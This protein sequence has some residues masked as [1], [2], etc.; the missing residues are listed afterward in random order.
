METKTETRL[1]TLPLQDIN[2]GRTN[3]RKVFGRDSLKELTKSILEKGILQP[4][5]VRPVND[6]FELVCGERRLRAATMAKLMEVPVQIRELTDEEVVEVQ[7]IENLEREDVHPLQEAEVLQKMLDSEKYTLSDLAA[8]LAKSETFI[9][10]RLSLNLLIKPWKDAFAAD[11]LSLGKAL[12]VARLTKNGQK[13]LAENAMDYVG[14]IKS[15]AAL[16]RYIDQNISRKL[17]RATFDPQDG[18]LVKKAG[19]CT[20]CQKRS[21]ANERLFPDIEAD[22][23]CFDRKCYELKVQAHLMV[24]IRNI[25]EAGEPV[26]FLYRSH[27]EETPSGFVKLFEKHDIRPLQEYDD[28]EVHNNGRSKE[29]DGLWLNGSSKG[30]RIRIFLPQRSKGKMNELSPEEQI[31]RIEQ[32]ASRALEL[33]AEKIHKRIIASLEGTEG[34]N[35]IGKIS[36]QP[37]DQLLMRLSLWNMANWDTREQLSKI[38]KWKSSRSQKVMVQR[39]EKLSE[40]QFTFMLRMIV[41]DKWKNTLPV[42]EEGIALRKLAEIVPEVAI[43]SIEKEQKEIANKR[44]KRTKERIQKLK[45]KC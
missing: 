10:Q 33:D 5:L 32:R 37:V 7:L 9:I 4:L 14:G 43:K 41:F 15:K 38:F 31:E 2:F 40:N 29:V 45:E 11:K 23:Q 12:V 34:L 19:P 3:P 20:T 26:H 13:E 30:Q 42:F 21:G 28:F 39:L 6:G 1:R 18:N 36:T 25:I 24:Q 17:E 22:D 8:K 27:G 44:I 16:E 35:Q